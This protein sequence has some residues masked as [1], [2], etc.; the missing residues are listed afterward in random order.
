MEISRPSIREI[1]R[2]FEATDDGQES[3]K[4]AQKSAKEGKAK[5][6]CQEKRICA[7][8]HTAKVWRPREPP[9]FCGRS[10]KDARGWVSIMRNY[11][12][13]VECSEKQ[14]VAFLSTFLRE[15]GHEWLLLH[16]KENGA[17]KNWKKLTQALI[18]RFGSNI[19]A[20]EAQMVLMK[21][22]QGKRKMRD[23][24]N[25]FQSLLCR[26]PSYEEKWMIDLFTWGL[27]PHFAKSGSLQYPNIITEVIK[28]AETGDAALRASQ[29]PYVTSNSTVEKLMSQEKKK[30]FGINEDKMREDGS[31]KIFHKGKK[32]FNFSMQRL[33][34]QWRKTA[35]SAGEMRRRMN[36]DSA[37]KSPV[38]YIHTPFH[39]ELER[40]HDLSRHHTV[41]GP[42]AIWRNAVNFIRKR[43]RAGYL[44][45]KGP[46][47][48]IN[49]AASACSKGAAFYTVSQGKQ[50]ENDEQQMQPSLKTR[51]GR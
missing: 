2:R 24:T 34:G 23:Y 36:N 40:E 20:Q 6:P 15:A 16:E 30:R 35:K 13:F 38:K 31:C 43:V 27:Q 41:N 7:P 39:V 29:K 47:I 9:L 50:K 5:I 10:T 4:S 28:Y 22:S 12:T 51:E 33:K 17:P 25:E 44:R 42:A 45:R 48:E 26:L 37:I 3:E 19:R 11:L 18:K 14:K 1:V 46:I 49:L 32:A 8:S 21:I